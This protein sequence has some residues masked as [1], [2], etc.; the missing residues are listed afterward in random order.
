MPEKPRLWS[1]YW[2]YWERQ[3]ILASL[4]GGC[5]KYSLIKTRPAGAQAVKNIFIVGIYRGRLHEESGLFVC[6]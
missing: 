6:C 2:S 1:N 4:A 5:I 3:K